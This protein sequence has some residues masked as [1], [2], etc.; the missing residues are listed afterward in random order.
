MKGGIKRYGA[1]YVAFTMKRLGRFT[2]NA[3]ADALDSEENGVRRWIRKFYA[4][5]LVAPNGTAASSTGVKPT[6][7]EWRG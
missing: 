4:H 7:W 2:A 1:V 6:V 3:L 5:Q